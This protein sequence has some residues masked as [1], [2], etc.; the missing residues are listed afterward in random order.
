MSFVELVQKEEF[1]S[2]KEVAD[3]AKVLQ[4]DVKKVRCD[5]RVF[6]RAQ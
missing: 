1:W 6:I 5:A 2:E 4:T 3:V